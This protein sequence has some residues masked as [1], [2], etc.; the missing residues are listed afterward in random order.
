MSETKQVEL[1]A[2]LLTTKLYIPPPRQELVS[3]PRLIERLNAGLGRKLSL[4]SA[5][6]GFGKTTLLS[7]WVHGRGEITGAVNAPLRV[8]WLSLDERDN[9]AV[10][11]WTYVVAAL[12]TIAPEIGATTLALLESSPGPPRLLLPPN[13]RRAEQRVNGASVV[14][15]A[16]E[17]GRTQAALTALINETAATRPGD[18]GLRLI[19]VLDDYHDIATAAIHKGLAFLLD[20]LPPFQ[21]RSS[22]GGLHLVIAGRSDQPLPL[23]RLRGRRQLSEL[24]EADLRFTPDE[25]ATFLNQVMGL[26]LSAQDVVTLEAR[27]EG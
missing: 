20:H 18:D 8:A 16:S 4:I 14:G 2:R 13:Q 24:T 15:Q 11:F 9:D 23:S 1:G 3:R 22:A 5:P 12:Q 17:S 19:L 27:T 21:E 25:A 26:G 10:R 6:A 7:E